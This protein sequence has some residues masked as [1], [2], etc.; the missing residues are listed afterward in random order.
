[1]RA[2]FWVVSQMI[3][4]FAGTG[5]LGIEALSRGAAEAVF[6]ESAPGALAVLR[7]RFPQ[8]RPRRWVEDWRPDA[9]FGVEWLTAKSTEMTEQDWDRVVDVNLKG[10]FFC[11][12]AVPPAGAAARS[13]GHL[14][15]RP[16]RSPGA[17][18]HDR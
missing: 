10:L 17:P 3:D 18:G 14:V 1:M 12:Q 4:G 16:Q 11:A 7:R 8:L 2:G 6:V 5:A 9:N 15:A 13:P